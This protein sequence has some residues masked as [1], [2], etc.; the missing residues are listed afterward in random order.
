M[1]AW[2]VVKNVPNILSNSF[3]SFSMQFSIFLAVQGGIKRHLYADQGVN[4]YFFEKNMKIE[5][6]FS[7]G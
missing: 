7:A 2:Y 5:Q 3:L 1:T 4:L 6:D